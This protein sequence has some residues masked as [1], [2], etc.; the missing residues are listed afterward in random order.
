MKR[1]HVIIECEKEDEG[2]GETIHETIH[3]HEV[4]SYEQ[5]PSVIMGRGRVDVPGGIAALMIPL[6]VR[7]PRRATKH[8]HTHHLNMPACPS[9]F[10]TPPHQDER[11]RRDANLEREAAGMTIE[12]V[13]S[14][15][16][17]DCARP[18]SSLRLRPPMCLSRVARSRCLVK[19]SPTFSCP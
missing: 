4:K 6:P 16:G 1:H 10:D 17:A 15:V 5:E 13:C 8:H 3:D 7:R 19:M 14:S 2:I 9:S 18:N 11:V 12:V